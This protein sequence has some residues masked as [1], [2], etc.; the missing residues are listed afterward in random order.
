MNQRLASQFYGDNKHFKAAKNYFGNAVLSSQ[1]LVFY[2]ERL[3]TISYKAKNN[4][5][6]YPTI[7]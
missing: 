4:N 3:T 1:D 7:I 6:F 2:P 5:F